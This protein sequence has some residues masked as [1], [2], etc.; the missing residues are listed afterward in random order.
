MQIEVL[1]AS[2]TVAI[3]LTSAEAEDP[4]VQAKLSAIYAD[5][6][7]KKFTPAVFHSA[8]FGKQHPQLSAVSFGNFPIKQTL[9]REANPPARCY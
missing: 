6:A 4:T 2:K 9:G 1:H 5:C 8:R 7:A 3:W